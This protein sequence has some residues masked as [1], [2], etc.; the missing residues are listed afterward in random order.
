MLRRESFSRDRR[1]ALIS[2]AFAA[3]WLLL[4]AFA[5]GVAAQNSNTPANASANAPAANSSPTPVPLAAVIAESDAALAKTREIDAFIQGQAVPPAVSEGLPATR[6]RINEMTA[7]TNASLADTP[8][9]EA[10][11][12]A[13][14]EWKQVL[15]RVVSWTTDMRDRSAAIEA[16]IAELNSLKELWRSS[17]AAFRTQAEADPAG[18]ESLVPDDVIRRI[19]SLLSAITETERRAVAKRAEFLTVESRL[20]ELQAEAEAMLSSLRQQRERQL[21]NIFSRSDRPLWATDPAGL[22]PEFVAGA[23]S[24]TLSL[25]WNDLSDYARR[26][27]GRFV[28][29]GVL[30]LVLIAGLL[31]A[32]RKI[33]PLVEEE[34][35]LR[36]PAAFFELPVASALIVS[37]LFSI[38]IYPQPPRLLSTLVAA[39]AIIPGFL[40]VRRIIESPWQYLLYGLLGLFVLDRVR[41]I[42]IDAELASRVIFSFEMLAAG[43]L[44]IWFYRSKKVAANVEASAYSAFERIRRLLPVGAGIFFGAFTASV[45]GFVFVAYL[46]GSGLLRTAYLA[47]F[48][49]TAVQILASGVAFLL[50]ARPFSGSSAVRNNRSLIVQK[51][52]RILAWTAGIIWLLGILNNFAVREAVFSAVADLLGY[53]FSIGE[54][55]FSIGDILLFAA[56]VW[57]A[58]LISRF[59][60]FVLE[61]DVYPRLGLGDGAS[62]AIS[63]VFHYLLLI[64]AFFIAISAVGFELSRFAIVAG[65]IGVGLGF[66]LQNIINNFVSGLI[67]LFEQPVK[68]GDTVQIGEHMGSLKSIGLRASVVRK[69][70]GSDVI[71]PNSQFIS[72]EVINWTMLDERRRIDIPVGV[73]YGSNAGEVQKL[74]LDIA[75]RY[76]QILTDPAPAALFLGLGESSIDFELRVWTVDTDGWVAL[77]SELVADVYNSLNEAGIGIPFPTREIYLQNGEGGDEPK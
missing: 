57:A 18:S 61:E 1:T 17:E 10:V 5:A 51:V 76:D 50:R 40:V 77:R 9:L 14:R 6:S 7:S 28:F 33:V 43:L 63:S 47:I 32:R 12:A 55:A 48:L 41:D 75:A 62:F 70:D 20:S 72:E 8:T 42:L 49:Y 73:K 58:F 64:L 16:R 15:D 71:V 35:K 11:N 23:A 60:R 31:W 22:R 19:G 44:L 26:Y 36:R 67:L 21:V 45:L 65:A 52:R 24:R 25:Q 69:V 27:P 13:E 66:G 34:P 59:V 37:A 74:L 38:L 56:M 53:R 3:G 30:L 39:A 46:V 68:V 4:A 29:H 2:R 54:I